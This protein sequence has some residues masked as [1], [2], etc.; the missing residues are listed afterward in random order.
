[1]KPTSVESISDAEKGVFQRL[2]FKPHYNSVLPHTRVLQPVDEFLAS[3][4]LLDLIL[5]LPIALGLIFYGKAYRSIVF[6]A[7]VWLLYLPAVG[8]Y[9]AF[10]VS[11]TVFIQGAWIPILIV[12]VA[13]AVFLTIFLKRGGISL[14]LPEIL[15]KKQEDIWELK[16]VEDFE[17]KERLEEAGVEGKPDLPAMIA[18]LDDMQY[19]IL[20]S[21]LSSGQFS[22]KELQEKV[23]ATSRGR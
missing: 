18:S 10:M 17:K 6:L 20:M 8:L 23:N 19:R 7:V 2:Q 4:I 3:I 22:K 13:G 5:S 1:M 12:A 16:G 14:P 9:I 15:Q 11:L 21:L